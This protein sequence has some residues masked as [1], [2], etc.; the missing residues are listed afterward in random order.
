MLCE[1]WPDLVHFNSHYQV[2][3]KHGMSLHQ[4]VLLLTYMQWKSI[5]AILY[6]WLFEIT[7]VWE[8]G[9]RGCVCVCVRPPGYE[10][11]FT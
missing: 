9:M 10:R 3:E 11:L 1:K 2:H 8:V 4:A 7:F 5:F 6:A